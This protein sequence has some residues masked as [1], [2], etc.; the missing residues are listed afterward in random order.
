S[1]PYPNIQQRRG[2]MPVARV[3]VAFILKSWQRPALRCLLPTRSPPPS[4]DA[5]RAE[6]AKRG[7]ADS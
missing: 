6:G 7:A 2:P 5:R 4:S 1:L 3:S